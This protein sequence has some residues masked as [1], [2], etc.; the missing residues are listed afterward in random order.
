MKRLGL[1]II[2]YAVFSILLV[3]CPLVTIGVN[4]FL[5][6]NGSFTLEN[7]ANLGSPEVRLTLLY[8]FAVAIRVTVLC[9]LLCYPAAYFLSRKKLGFSQQISLLFILPMGINMLLYTFSTVAVLDFLKIPPG[10]FALIIG[11]IINSMPFMMQPLYNCLSKIG[12]Q[13]EEASADLGAGRLMTFFR[14]T[15]PLSM[16]G[17]I[18]GVSMVLFPSLS[19][20]AISELLTMNKVRLFGSVIESAFSS[21]LIGYGSAMSILMLAL[22]LLTQLLDRRK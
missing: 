8:S 9:L 13:Y 6:E 10:R 2:P 4:A 14:V 5:D 17:I 18:S 16:P 1:F 21:G 15:V 7:F 19:T 3:I 12:S 20:F 11:L 22:I